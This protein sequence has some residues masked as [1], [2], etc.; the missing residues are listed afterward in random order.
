MEQNNYVIALDVGGSSVKSAIVANDGRLRDEPLTTPIDSRETADTILTTFTSIIKL[1]I[2]ELGTRSLLGVACGFPGPFEYDTG[3]SH[4]QG[5][6]KYEAIYGLNIRQELQRRLGMA[7]LDI[8][9]RNDAEA[10]IVGEAVWGNGRGFARVIG[11][12]LGTGIG[13]AFLIDGKPVFKGVGIPPSGWLYPQLFNGRQAD[14]VFSIRGLLNALGDVGVEVDDIKQAADLARGNHRAARQ[15]FAQFGRELGSFLSPWARS[16][17]ADL[18]LVLGGIAN[19]FD[20][21]NA[22]LSLAISRDVLPGI[23]AAKAPLL[24]AARLFFHLESG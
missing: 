15:V 24:G 16:F 12:T 10:A 1:Y 2:N 13:S 11:V 21:F 17:R 8:R 5:V 19:T 22:E 18:V 3:V 9:F 14:D 6:A 4:I 23:L 20:L 7:D